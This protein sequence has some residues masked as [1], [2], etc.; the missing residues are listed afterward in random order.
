MIMGKYIGKMKE[1]DE[2][3]FNIM[4]YLSFNAKMF[5]GE[6]FNTSESNILVNKMVE[7][8]NNGDYK[9]A[10]ILVQDYQ[11]DLYW[12]I[13][14]YEGLTDALFEVIKNEL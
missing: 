4:D 8:C 13:I 10:L 9:L 1:L 6:E 2:K 3:P 11:R 5:I 12:A 14:N 7:L